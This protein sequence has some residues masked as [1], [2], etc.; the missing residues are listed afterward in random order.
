MDA[1]IEALRV[2]LGELQGRAA[3]TLA[4]VIEGRLRALEARYPRHKFGFFDAMGSTFF[5]VSPP[6]LGEKRLDPYYWH[7]LRNSPE[8]IRKISQELRAELESIVELCAT[9]E[10]EFRVNVGVIPSPSEEVKKKT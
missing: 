3:D 2:E 7:E 5:P 6:F 9:V 1:R 8:W 10:G 4:E